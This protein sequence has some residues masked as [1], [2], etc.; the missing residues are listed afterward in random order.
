MKALVL[1]MSLLS[2]INCAIPIMMNEVA[3]ANQDIIINE[4]GNRVQL[5]QRAI[6]KES[7]SATANIET[8]NVD[9]DLRYIYGGEKGYRNY[10]IWNL[11]PTENDS[12]D[13]S[14][15]FLC[16]K[17]VGQ[18]LYLYVYDN[19]NRNSD[20]LSA[21]FKI[22]KSKVQNSVTGEFEETFSLYNARFV[23]SYGYKQRFIKFAIDSIVNLDEDVRLYISNGN[24]IYQDQSNAKNYYKSLEDIN[25]E[26]AFKVGSNND[27][28]YQY[29]KD[30]YIKITEKDV[31][32]MLVNKDTLKTNNDRYYSA[33]ENFYCFFNTDRAID[34]LQE[35]CYDYQLLDYNA[36]CYTTRDPN[37]P[38]SMP[39][40]YVKGHWVYQSLYNNFDKSKNL[41]REIYGFKENSIVLKSNVKLTNEKVVVNVERP[42]FLWWKQ[43]VKVNF[44]T[45]V[46]CNEIMN[47]SSN[48]YNALKTFI[49]NVNNEKYN[50]DG[51][52]YKWC[53]NALSTTRETTN[54]E[55]KDAFLGMFGGHLELT[56]R[57]HEIKQL[58]IL[59]LKFRT[60]NQ[61]FTFN[62]L[63]IPTDTSG[64]YLADVPFETLGDLIINNA[65][66]AFYWLK[67]NLGNV[68]K[69]IV[70]LAISLV[71]I[72]FLVICWPVIS[73]VMKLIGQGIKSTSK[74]IE[75]RRNRKGQQ[76]KKGG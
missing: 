13:T 67:N 60:N 64:V 6:K 69:N 20:I 31:K 51:Y 48:E 16:A 58:L 59:C 52:K 62:A 45:I 25:H 28:M 56:S 70:P 14:Y 34:E 40:T 30:D 21:T 53:F 61:E 75:N 71:I 33:Y 44:D 37:A 22:S 4:E 50:K 17:P 19:D 26:F 49:T 18:N 39:G 68:F 35:V 15:K 8:T 5:R 32:L 38:D 42:Y 55:L 11:L 54:C 24:I 74:G 10:N 66:N 63:D 27:F 41:N 2:S 46:N 57:C 3:I 76:K 73:S 9:Y 23:N 65:V 36:T 1:M 72:M 12:K 29:F 47:N 43:N 7:S